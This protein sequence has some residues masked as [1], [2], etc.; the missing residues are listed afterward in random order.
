VIKRIVLHPAKFGF[1]LAALS[2][3]L[4][5]GCA[6]VAPWERGTLAKPHMA[7]DTNPQDATRRAHMF[8]SREA[9]TG[10]GASQG[11]GCGCN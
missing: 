8:S 1:I 11:G 7:L 10:A 5:Q 4:L 9:A 3:T 2:A 6:T